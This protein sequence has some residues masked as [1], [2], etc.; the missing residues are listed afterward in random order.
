MRKLLS[1][2][3]LFFA[4]TTIPAIAV[5]VSF[6][7]STTIIGGA[8]PQPGGR[9]A[10]A[11]TLTF[12]PSF[13]SGTSN[14]GD[15]VFSLSQCIAAPPPTSYFNGLFDFDFKNGNHLWG[16]N[17]GTLSATA[18]PNVFANTSNYVVTGGTGI[19]ANATGEF[20]GL[21]TVRRG[22]PGVPGLAEQ[23][24]EGLVDNVP[25]PIT[26]MMFGA[27]LAGLS[28]MRNRKKASVTN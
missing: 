9:C 17:F 15:F 4:V 14:F 5:P 27:G 12:D 23:T 19:F 26:L 10:P 24:F 1:A 21:G 13:S 3:L 20:L 16:T 6:T 2:S 28:V 18:D 22:S 8:G 25:E 7:G 11:L